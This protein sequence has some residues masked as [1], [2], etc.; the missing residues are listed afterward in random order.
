[1]SIGFISYILCGSARDLGVLVV[2][3]HCH[4]VILSYVMLYSDY[5]SV[6][7]RVCHVFN[8][9]SA[10]RGFRFGV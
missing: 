3:Y 10:G 8:R 1:M 4:S 7:V 5:D 6:I 9:E 2:L